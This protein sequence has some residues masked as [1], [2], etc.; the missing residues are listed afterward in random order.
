MIRCWEPSSLTELEC[1]ASTAQV[2]FTGNQSG[3]FLLHRCFSVRPQEPCPYRLLEVSG[4]CFFLIHSSRAQLCPTLCD[5]MD[6]SRPGSSVH[7]ILQARIL[8]QVAIP[9]SRGSFKPRSPAS[10]ADSLQLS[11]R[12]WSPRISAVMEMFYL[13]TV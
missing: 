2:K 1:T 12:R 6:C 5:P 10:Q 8:E 13:Y 4:N 9:F 3:M 11:H 7:V